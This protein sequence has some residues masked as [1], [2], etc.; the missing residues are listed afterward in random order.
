MKKKI[1][2]IKDAAAVLG[3]EGIS[4]V[5]DKEWKT[6]P[7]PTEGELA[8]EKHPSP[9]ARS[10]PNSR[11]NLVQYN[12]DKSK[13][14]KEKIVRSLIFKSTR[15]DTDLI[16]FFDG[17]LEDVLIECLLPIREA[18][19]DAEEEKLFFGIV[20]QFVADFPRGE[21]SA[22]DVDD[23]SN[24]ALNRILELRLLKAAKKSP[25]MV[26]DAANTI[27][28]FRK[29][30]EKL[31]MNLASRRT[32]RVD[33]KNKQSFSI[34]DL[35]EAFDQKKRDSLEQRARELEEAQVKFEKKKDTSLESVDEERGD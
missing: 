21:L 24:L 15:P 5:V 27:E 25:K 10:N 6:A 34:V 31:K 17:L 26:M 7:L 20:K 3:E 12:K 14:T 35:A 29:N 4:E 2:D 1:V 32:D 22:S 18:L 8:K 11:A 16:A 28:K 19:Q 33:T 30:S 23:I 13:E 9:K